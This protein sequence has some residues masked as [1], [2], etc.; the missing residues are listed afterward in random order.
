MS[1]QLRPIADAHGT[2]D[3]LEDLFEN[4]PCGYISAQPD[5]R[6]GRVN[7][8]LA[9][10]LGH[11]P[12]ELVGRRVPDLFNIA[13]KIYYETHFA[14]LLRMQGAFHEVALDLVR[15]DGGL[16]PVLLNA[17]ERR[18]PDG[19]VR[20]IRITVFNASD[21]RRYERDLLEARRTAEQA[22]TDLRELNADLEARVGEAVAERMKAEEALRQAQKMEAIG[23]LTGGVAH[24]FNNLLTVILGGL[25]T[26]RR[27]VSTLPVSPATERI[28]RS[29]RMA[30]HGAERA[31]TLTARLLAFARRQ[32]LDPKP[33]DASRL[34]TNLADL[35]QRT[36]GETIALETVTG[37]GLW[38]TQADPGELE[39]ALVNLAVNARDAMPA[40]GR[41]TIE[42]GNAHLDEDYVAQVPEP[43]VAGQYVL[44][45]V[46]DTGTGMSAETLAKVFEPFFTTKEVG[47]GTGLG[48]S[49]VYG[50]VRQSNGHIRIYSE[51]GE[52]TTIKIYLPRLISEGAVAEADEPSVAAP[53]HGGV[54]TIL[55]VEDHDDLRTFSTGILRELGYEVLEAANGHSALKVLQAAHDV[56]LLF[57][58]VVLP[59]GMDGRRLADEARRRRP[60][61]KVLF[62]TGYTRNAIVHNG[63]L[64]LG[65]NLISKPFSFERLA[66]KVREVLDS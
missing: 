50:F 39:N 8:T 33:L 5:S 20:F 55:V 22:S 48:L 66:S 28:E 16:L 19:A 11:K 3:D 61:I 44:I 2:A 30:S 1:D 37:G 56:D 49:Q 17:V 42:T 27:Q 4:A 62:T 7:S 60:G 46:S 59:E 36:L 13:G 51:V 38:R 24:D 6:I 54:E 41:L 26:I 31:T 25:D 45:A 63:R 47:K 29:V 18:D 10:W 9:K 32:P 53:T 57:T 43:V 40:G 34:V 23:Q 58:D 14:P 35:L 65:V 21:R 52:G 64:D 12:E 15:A